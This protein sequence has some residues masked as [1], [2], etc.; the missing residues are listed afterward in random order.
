MAKPAERSNGATGT[1]LLLV[2]LAG[3]FAGCSKPEA[4]AAERRPAAVESEPA[5]AS[6]P[7]EA[8]KTRDLEEK[9]ASYDDRFKEIQNSD[10][11][12]EEKARAAGDLVDEQQQTVR[13]AE[14]GPADEAPA[15]PPQ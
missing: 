7:S 14:D 10:M 13:Q 9:S 11:S 6:A 1:A 15:D 2:I 12:A 3:S 8:A 4:T 5:A